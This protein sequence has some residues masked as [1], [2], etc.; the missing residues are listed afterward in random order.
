MPLPESVKLLLFTRKVAVRLPVL[1]GTKLIGNVMAAPASRL[2]GRAGNW[3]REKTVL[4]AARL[5][6]EIAAALVP[7]F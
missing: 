4:A 5:I 3:E 6:L 1:L 2:T 7:V